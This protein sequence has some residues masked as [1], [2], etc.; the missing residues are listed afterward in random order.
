MKH[1]ASHGPRLHL[2]LI[3]VPFS[4]ASF[5]R[6]RCCA[7]GQSEE[8]ERHEVAGGEGGR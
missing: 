3:D 4:S 8:G 1:E 5:K 2:L 7:T 6:D